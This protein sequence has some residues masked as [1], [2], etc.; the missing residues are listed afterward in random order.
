MDNIFIENL[1]KLLKAPSGPIVIDVRP[2]DAF[3][4]AAGVIPG[5]VRR[6][7]DAVDGW[8]FDLEFAQPIVVYCANG[9]ETSQG[10]AKLLRESSRPAQYLEGGFETW[11]A[12]GNAVAPKSRYPAMGDAG[13]PQDRSHR[14]PVAHPALHRPERAFHLCPG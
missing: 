10:V 2:D 7:A 11:E 5:A 8:A 3:A 14:L 13:A 9:D 1:T 12:S 4:A 6:D